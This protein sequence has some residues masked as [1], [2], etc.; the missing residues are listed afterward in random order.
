MQAGAPGHVVAVSSVMQRKSE[1]NDAS[2]A[3]AGQTTSN[4]VGSFGGFY[5]RVRMHSLSI[6][7]SLLAFG[8]LEAGS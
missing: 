7:L 4:V 5:N 2:M 8:P 1:A 3:C 6:Q